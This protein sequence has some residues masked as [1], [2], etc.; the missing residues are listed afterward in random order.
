MMKFLSK[1]EIYY[2][3]KSSCPIFFS[4]GLKV[5]TNSEFWFECLLLDKFISNIFW[6]KKS[7]VLDFLK[8]V[9]FGLGVQLKVDPYPPS[10]CTSFNGIV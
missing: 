5:D 1:S 8:V 4:C 6:D 7:I 9:F 3:Y 10:K 2:R